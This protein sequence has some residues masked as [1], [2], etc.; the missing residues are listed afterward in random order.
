MIENDLK[1]LPWLDPERTNIHARAGMA[2]IEPK[3][4]SNDL[5]GA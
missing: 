3:S 5:S 1:N 4:L 2:S